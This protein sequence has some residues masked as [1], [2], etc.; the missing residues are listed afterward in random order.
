MKVGVLALQGDFE[1]HARML[2]P[3]AEPI[4][5]RTSEQLA[6][7]DALV[8]P[9]GESTT[10]RK[11]ATHYGLLDGLRARAAAGVPIFGTCA[12]RIACASEIADGD[13]PILPVVDITVRRNAY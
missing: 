12:G 6:S 8:I 1:A 2:K 3:L 11:L 13:E 10:I 5:V 4:E 7:V 9:G